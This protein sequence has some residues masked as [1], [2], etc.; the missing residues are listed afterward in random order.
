MDG[1]ATPV[2]DFIAWAA[3]EIVD[4]FVALIKKIPDVLVEAKLGAGTI[5][6]KLDL[7]MEKIFVFQASGFLA[8][9]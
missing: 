3:R 5:A 6:E 2:A 4:K 9:H 8:P 1:I 7:V